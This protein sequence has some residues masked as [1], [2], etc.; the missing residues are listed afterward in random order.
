MSF[1]DVFAIF[2]MKVLGILNLIL[3][4]YRFLLLLRMRSF[5]PIIFPNWL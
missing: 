5:F 3:C 2:S 4:A 1:N